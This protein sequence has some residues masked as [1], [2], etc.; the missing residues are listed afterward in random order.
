MLRPV[1]GVSPKKALAFSEGNTESWKQLEAGVLAALEGYH[2]TLD[3]SRLDALIPRLNQIDADMRSYAYE[4][5]AMGLTGMDVAMPWRNRLKPFLEGA[6]AAHTYMVHIGVGEALALMRRRPEPYLAQLDP[7]LRWLALDGY[8][9]HKGFFA[10][11]RYIDAQDVP[12]FLSPYA[13]QI[14][15]QGIGRAIWFL[16]G[17]NVDLVLAAVSRFP[18]TRHADLWCGVGV[19][20]AYAGGADPVS[21]ESLRRGAGR[22]APHLAL[23]AAVV[24]KGRTRAGN[25][26]PHSD[27][28][29]EIF[30]DTSSSVAARIVDGAFQNLPLDGPEPAFAVLQQR[31]IQR[32]MAPVD[33]VAEHQE[34][35]H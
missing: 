27:L 10:Q 2:A 29:C 12:S 3:D 28:A 1:V 22:Y 15:S 34:V 7:V 26:V 21:I 18:T 24:A 4:G 30:C 19:G 8:G 33:G 5:A 14:F 20:C 11:R 32:F 17:G 13:R 25:P 31:L 16:K 23:G 35:A 9:F 6:G